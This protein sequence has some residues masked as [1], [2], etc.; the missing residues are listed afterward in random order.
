[1]LNDKPKL[2]KSYRVMKSIRDFEMRISKEFALGTVPGM[3]HLYVG[4][5]AV[6]AGICADLT[7]LDYIAS[8]HRGHGHCIAKGCDIRGMAMELFRKAEGLCKG[9]GGSMHILSLIHI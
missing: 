9:K 8:T 4:Q 1:M 6:A 2:L 7:E 3:T 5:E